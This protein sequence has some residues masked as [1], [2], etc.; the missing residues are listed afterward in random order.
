MKFSSLAALKIVQITTSIATSDENFY[1]NDI[2]VSVFH[3][4]RC[5]LVTP[6]CDIDLGQLWLR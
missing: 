1:Q 2:S 6:Y 3:L 5:G 4:T